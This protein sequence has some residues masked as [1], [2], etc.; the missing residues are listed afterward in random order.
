MDSRRK[1]GRRG[2]KGDEMCIA[3]AWTKHCRSQQ[4]ASY[5]DRHSSVATVERLYLRP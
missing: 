4:A 2:A 1:R 3:G 5:E